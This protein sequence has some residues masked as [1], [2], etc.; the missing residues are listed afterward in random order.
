M[1]VVFGL[2]SKWLEI[3]SPLRIRNLRI[4]LGGQVISLVGTWM[5]MTA[6][7]WVVWQLSHSTVALGIVAMFGSMPFLLLG[8]VSGAL[9]DRLD[10]RKLLIISQSAAMVLAFLL[11]I[12]VQ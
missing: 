3:F 2:I 10:R 8:P 12:L 1:S 11:A 5:Q 4:Y 7:S 6:Q 9:A